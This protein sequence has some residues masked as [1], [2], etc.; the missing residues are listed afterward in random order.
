[1]S[2]AR[3]ERGAILVQVAL[4]LIAV[5]GFSA[6]VIDYGVLWAS[7]GQA[8][9][10]ADAAA[11]AGAVAWAWD[12]PFG[13]KSDSGPAKRNALSVALAHKVWGEAPSVTAADISFPTCPDGTEACVR[14]NVYRN[15]IPTFFAR[16]VGVNVQDVRAT[17]TAEA[18]LGNAVDCIKPFAVA[19]KWWERR[20]VA[21]TWTVDST[22]DSYDKFGNLLPPV[23]DLYEPPTE[24]SFG[25]GFHPYGPLNDYGL[26]LTLK[27]G[28]SNDPSA[29]ASG[30]F[31]PLAFPNDKGGDD[32]RDNIAGCYPT[33]AYVGGTFK[34]Q[35]EPGNMIGPTKQGVN[36]L[37]ERDPGASWDTSTN[38][39]IGS[40]FA[41]SPRIVPIPLIN[42]DKYIAD[43]KAGRTDV[44]IVNILGFFVNRMNGNDVEGYLCA[45]PG[46]FVAGVPNVGNE[47]SFLRTIQ[48]VR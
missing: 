41:V 3:A 25:S 46:K 29:L 35:T 19:D 18:G 15:S 31:M 47:S 17:A 27:Q 23:V 2:P 8:Q 40:A 42:V 11:L 14:V 43:G 6:F 9:N 4:A 10:A 37:I 33:P 48:L 44:D 7:R 12:A 39:V 26:K 30:W 36:L 24:T 5:L 32:F 1:M 38:K 13:D 34:T 28:A 20:P 21:A 22:Y 16:L 45:L